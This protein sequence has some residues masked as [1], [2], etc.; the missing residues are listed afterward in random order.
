MR[1]LETYLSTRDNNFLLVRFVSAFAV[2]YS[3]AFCLSGLAEPAVA[4]SGMAVG[5]WAV[6]VF[7]VVS[8]F[9]VA[10]SLVN[11]AS[12]V[13][14]TSARV[15]RIFPGLIV[16]AVLTV[17]VLGPLCTELPLGRYFSSL[18]T[19]SYLA[20]NI[21]L[22]LKGVQFSLPGVFEK[23]PFPDS[24]NG[25]LW[26]LPIEVFMYAWLLAYGLAF[27]RN[28]LT[29]VRRKRILFA[30]FTATGAALYLHDLLHNVHSASALP[31]S[32]PTYF[33]TG[34]L[35]YALSR[36]IPLSFWLCAASVAALALTL[37]S[38][39]LL[40][41]LHPL[42]TAYIV[43]YVCYVPAGFVRRF[44]R[45]G[46]YSY[47][48]YIY[49]FPVQQALA[50]FPAFAPSSARPDTVA[51]AY[52]AVAGAI[53][54]ILSILSWHLV[55]HPALGHVKQAASW[56]RRKEPQLTPKTAGT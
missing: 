47:G 33:W 42:L 22:V 21:L 45:L 51:I 2:L 17:F 35:F 55:E 38:H 50:G 39:N 5:Q 23:H 1:T 8:G 3:H 6:S 49:A 13:E 36:W 9:L 56:F 48:I 46:D 54:L 27:H 11:H 43:L 34:G 31:F 44:N 7:F 37:T 15:L 18:K 10:K 19:Y 20:R 52:L 53:T 26:T 28:W 14:Y 16:A 12:L 40:F 30:L 32:L 41:A 4:L 24:V 25:S 29:S